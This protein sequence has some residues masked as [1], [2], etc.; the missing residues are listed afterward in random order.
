MRPLIVTFTH[1]FFASILAVTVHAEEVRPDTTSADTAKVKATETK[2]D[3]TAKKDKKKT[4]TL[5]A[6]LCHLVYHYVKEQIQY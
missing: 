3:T 2:A 5:N 4:T 1:V 6:L